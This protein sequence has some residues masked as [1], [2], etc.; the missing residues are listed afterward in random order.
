MFKFSFCGRDLLKLVEMKSSVILLIFVYLTI[1][2]SSEQHDLHVKFVDDIEEFKLI[3]SGVH[4]EYLDVHSFD[5]L[6][7]QK[8]YYIGARIRGKKIVYKQQN[9]F[10]YFF[11]YYK[12]KKVIVWYLLQPKI[13]IGQNLKIS[14][15]HFLIQVVEVVLLLVTLVS[16]LHKVLI[17]VKHTSQEEELVLNLL[18]L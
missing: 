8:N 15:R 10:K 16:M 18:Q 1:N 3:H 2:V 6:K 9:F 7:Q 11:L 14:Q 13:K 4:V 12:K 5:N 17:L